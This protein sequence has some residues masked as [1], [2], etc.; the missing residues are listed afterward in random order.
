MLQSL[1]C[2]V[3][4]ITLECNLKCS[5][6]GSSAGKKLKNEL[7]THECIKVCEQLADLNCINVA[8]MGGE[9]FLKKDWEKIAQC[10]V[11]LGMKLNIVS[12]G[13]ILNHNLKELIRLQPTVV[14]ISLDGL[15]K[16]HDKI[17]GMKGSFDQ[18]V[19]SVNL[20]R[21]NNIQTTIITTVSK[22]NFK[23]LPKIEKLIHN[24]GINW[25]IQLASPFGNFNK[26]DMLSYE[27]FYAVGLLIAAWR[28]KHHFLN[29]PVIGAHCMGYH[30]EIMEN[31]VW[32][33]CSAGR[34]T[35]G[36][37][38]QGNV[39]GCLAM[40]NDRLVEANLRE[41]SLE[42]IWKNKNA[43]TY[44]RNFTKKNLGEYCTN[45]EFGESCKGGCNSVSLSTTNK[46]HNDPFC[47][48]R[49]EKEIMN[50]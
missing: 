12:N 31:F 25:Q 38:S 16:I 24:K 8:L 22:I 47:F 43:F 35:I 21:K 45:C 11:D 2:A 46:C 23:E 34:T 28:A 29:M 27:E 4:E 32:D 18:A 15:R 14:G 42:T 19:K 10:I 20:L 3:W 39:V 7:K 36:I 33:G 44:N 26:K 17:R 6:C 1:E 50:K 37:T 49:I 40:G 30:S 13:F 41:Q 5:H 48:H 9:P